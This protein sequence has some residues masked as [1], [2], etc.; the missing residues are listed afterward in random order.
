MVNLIWRSESRKEACIC[1]HGKSVK[2]CLTLRKESS[3]TLFAKVRRSLR[4]PLLAFTHIKSAV[5]FWLATL[6]KQSLELAEIDAKIL[7]DN[8]KATTLKSSENLN[9]IMSLSSIWVC[10]HFQCFQQIRWRHSASSCHGQDPVSE[11]QGAFVW[12]TYRH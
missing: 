2:K 8:Q 10:L 3:K 6:S 11:L 5:P 4:L 1:Y 7:E 12:K 9:C